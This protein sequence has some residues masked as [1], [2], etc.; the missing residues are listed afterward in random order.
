V[1]YFYLVKTMRNFLLLLSFTLLFNGFYHAAEA[2]TISAGATLGNISACVGSS[3]ASPY[4]QQFTVTG[5]GLTANVTVTAPINFEVSLTANGG[6]GN[7]VNM[8]QTGGIANGIVYVRSSASAAVGNIAGNVVLKSPGAADQNVAVKGIVNAPPTVSTVANQIVVTGSN[9]PAINFTGSG[10][11]FIWT[12]SNPNIGLAASGSGNIPT[13]KAINNGTTPV[14]ATITVTPVTSGLFYGLSTSG[15]LSP[16]TITVFDD[17]LN[18]NTASIP[19]GAYPTFI[20]ASADESRVYVA[21]NTGNSVSVINAVTNAVT[22]TIPVGTAP[23]FIT[24][25]PDDKRLFVS[26]SV[27]NNISV[28]DATTATVVATIPVGGP[29]NPSTVGAHRSA[30]TPDGGHLYVMNDQSGAIYVINTTTYQVEATIAISIFFDS[31]GGRIFLSPDGTRCYVYDGLVG[32]LT[33]INTVTNSKLSVLGPNIGPAAQTISPDGSRLYVGDSNNNLE[34]VNTA[35]NSI[36]TSIALGVNPSETFITPDG[37]YLYVLSHTPGSVFVINTATNT[38]VNTI[39]NDYNSGGV[40]SPDGSYLYVFNVNGTLVINTATNAVVSSLS[41]YGTGAAISGIN[42]GGVPITFTITVKP[43]LPPVIA[44]AS[45]ISACFGNSSASPFIQQITVAKSGLTADVTATAP[46]DFEVSL[47]ANGGYGNS[48]SITQT[49]GVVNRMVYVRSAAS[50][51]VGNIAGNVVLTSTGIADEDV[52]V[53]GIINASPTVNAV[54]N[55]IVVSGTATAPANFT[56]TAR[57]YTWTNS[58]PTIGLTAAGAGNIP[59]FTALNSSNAPVTATITVTSAPIGFIYGISG[60][61]VTVING[62]NNTVAATI[63]V[64]QFPQGG[65]YKPRWEPCLCKQYG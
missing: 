29:L 6:Y 47:T 38:I 14:T 24:L 34:V 30:I 51:P 25:S 4:I 54:A 53:S 9:A 60:N 32:S 33:V 22:N 64:G 13:F 61:S 62:T 8:A 36:I 41:N 43:L 44:V 17:A 23:S 12:N 3:S 52:A 1:P 42:C 39:P 15:F 20:I 40:L 63:P 27:S 58:N 16:G 2:Q 31:I 48:V 21:N 10:R 18:R 65:Y 59:S 50:A 5:S 46:P 28:I 11:D 55:Q 45:N 37:K 57:G 7:I 19:V 49:G 56:G 35:N 26:N